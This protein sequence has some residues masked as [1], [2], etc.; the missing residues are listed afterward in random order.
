MSNEAEDG[1]VED[2]DPQSTEAPAVPAQ[3]SAAKPSHAERSDRIAHAMVGALNRH[4][5]AEA[6]P[7]RWK[8]KPT[9]PF[10][11]IT[12][13]EWAEARRRREAQEEAR[14]LACGYP[15]AVERAKRNA[16]PAKPP[17]LARL[18][19]LVKPVGAFLL[20]GLVALTA[21]DLIGTHQSIA[22]FPAQFVAIALFLASMVMPVVFGAWCG[23]RIAERTGKNW[24]GWLLA[25]VVWIVV[26]LP[27]YVGV[28]AIPHIGWRIAAMQGGD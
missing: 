12:P 3:D 16:R 22:A 9:A 17:H 23:I 8:P 28:R 25:A 1:V 4:V 11:E 21:A 6:D 10:P 19:Y 5:L 24:T 27:V 20:A 2:P 15:P 13:A 18:P 14:A 7:P 26:G